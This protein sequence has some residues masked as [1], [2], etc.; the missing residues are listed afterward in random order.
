MDKRSLS[1]LGFTLDGAF[2][3][4]SII[5]LAVGI[6]I[7]SRLGGRAVFGIPRKVDTSSAT[8]IERNCL[9]P[10]ILKGSLCLSLSLSLSRY[11]APSLRGLYYGHVIFITHSYPPMVITDGSFSLADLH[12]RMPT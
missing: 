5:G 8:K 11:L 4:D 1:L 12:D 2:F 7:V 10:I 3:V 9:L 6:T